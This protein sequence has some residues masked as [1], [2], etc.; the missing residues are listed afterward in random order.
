MYFSVFIIPYFI[1]KSKPFPR[2]FAD[3]VPF[4]CPRCGANFP[5]NA[6]FMGR[7]PASRRVLERFR[8]VVRNFV[9]FCR[10]SNIYFVYNNG[11]LEE[12]YQK[13]LTVRALHF[14]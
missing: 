11:K 13:I 6:N 12:K 8:T 1:K 5:R 10:F 4:F 3:S 2:R 7:R 14:L 9:Y